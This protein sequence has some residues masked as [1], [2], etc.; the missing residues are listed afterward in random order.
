M[1]IILATFIALSAMRASADAPV[2]AGKVYAGS[3]GESVAVI[4][5]TAKGPQGEK[6]VLLYVQGTD[7]PF[8]GKALLHSVNE[9]SRGVDY[10][11]E[12]RGNDFYTLVVRDSWGSK[13]Y[14]LWVPE[15][16]KAI[17]VSYDEKRSQALKA[18]DIH[19]LHEK[20]KKDGTLSRMAAFNRKEREAG[21][22]QTLA[23]EV[24]ALNEACGTQVTASIDWKSVSD[25]V[26]KKY[27][28]SSYCSSPLT[29]LRRLCDSAAGKKA[30][31]AKVKKVTC[32][33]GSELKLAIQAGAVSWTTEKDAANQ[34]EFATKFF[35]KNL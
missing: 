20:Q 24:K 13:R 1:R 4:P 30:I 12:Y 18:D 6:Q 9:M 23:E 29:A 15:Q 22:E 3:E 21:N 14:E 5:L 27:S 19:A 2:G 34:E 26:I 8:D 33:F 25:E 16:R 11:T 28:I 7:S 10:I 32:Q 31:Q 35:E 17:I